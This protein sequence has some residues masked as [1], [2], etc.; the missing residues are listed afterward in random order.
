MRP[1]AV[2]LSPGSRDI[3]VMAH[4]YELRVV[5]YLMIGTNEYAENA[6]A[7]PATMAATASKAKASKATAALRLDYT[8]LIQNK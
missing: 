8:I 1:F 5:I 2:M 7:K 6:P 4:L 3:P